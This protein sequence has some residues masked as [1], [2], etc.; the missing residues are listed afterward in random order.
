MSFWR[1]QIYFEAIP[2]RFWLK[3]NILNESRAGFG[4]KKIFWVFRE[5]FWFKKNILK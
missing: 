1:R 2:N 5:R 3:K 4:S